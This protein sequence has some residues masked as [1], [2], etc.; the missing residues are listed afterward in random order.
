MIVVRD[1]LFAQ[2][3]EKFDATVRQNRLIG[4]VRARL[5]RGSAQKF[6][7]VIRRGKADALMRVR[8]HLAEIDELLAG[9]AGE[10]EPD[11]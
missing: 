10:A 3:P 11:A 5:G 6:R 9:A 4:Q 1:A 2:V 8:G 7:D